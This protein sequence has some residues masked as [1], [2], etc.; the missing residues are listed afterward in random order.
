M[1]LKC[2]FAMHEW[3]GCKCKNCG[4]T[5]DE[6]HDWA[7]DCEKCAK[8]G[9]TLSGAHRWTG[10]KCAKCGKT[11][12]EG[13]DRVADCEKCAKCGKILSGAHSWSGCKCKKCRKTRD[14][15][16][17]WHGCKCAKCGK[18]RDEGHDWAADCEKCTKCGETGNEEHD[19]TADNERCAKCGKARGGAAISDFLKSI[20]VISSI[21]WCSLKTKTYYSRSKDLYV[22]LQGSNNMLKDRDT[23][24]ALG[25]TLSELSRKIVSRGYSPSRTAIVTSPCP[26]GT[27]GCRQYDGSGATL[28]I[29]RRAP[30]RFVAHEFVHDVY[31]FRH[32]AFR[33]EI[34]DDFPLSDW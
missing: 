22:N 34:K 4:K 24:E 11:R 14:E 33:D 7:A 10:C 31:D 5:R 32:H 15:G 26:C 23:F 12:D 13:H 28:M 9:K 20:P 1:N 2:L 6:G 27:I 8:C 3:T 17:D 21:T 29:I 18:T 16:H 30:D 19:W 25:E